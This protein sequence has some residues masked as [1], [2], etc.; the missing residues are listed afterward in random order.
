MKTQSLPLTV[1]TS[2]LCEDYDAG[3]AY[4]HDSRDSVSELVQRI[5]EDNKEYHRRHPDRHTYEP[6]VLESLGDLTEWLQN[7]DHFLCLETEEE[8]EQRRIEEERR[9]LE[10]YVADVCR[11]RGIDSGNPSA[12]LDALSFEI[13]RAHSDREGLREDGLCA[14]SYGIGGGQASVDEWFDMSNECGFRAEKAHRAIEWVASNC[15][16]AFAQWEEGKHNQQ[17]EE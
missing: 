5:N 15:P 4:R 17:E 6:L 7:D 9:N 13:D 10:S 14:T 12:V 2:W 11:R 1:I 8:H 3:R 16:L